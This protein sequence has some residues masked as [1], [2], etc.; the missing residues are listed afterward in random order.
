MGNLTQYRTTVGCSGAF[1]GTVSPNRTR[2]FSL[3]EILAV[4]T[5]L[6]VLSSIVVIKRGGG[7]RGNALRNAQAVT[8][9]LLEL[10]RTHATMQGVPVRLLIYDGS[11][12][13]ERWRRV[14]VVRR[15]GD[16]WE[17]F[18]PVTTLPEGVIWMPP[19]DMDG[20][21]IGSG[22]TGVKRSTFGHLPSSDQ[23]M[24]LTLP[25]TEDN[26]AWIFYE[27]GPEGRAVNSGQIV[28]QSVRS[29]GSGN[30]LVVDEHLAAGCRLRRSGVISY[31]NSPEEFL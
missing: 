3:I 18:Q 1:F 17:Q 27:F 7:G 26:A 23:R 10:A 8:G 21:V 11:N 19:A 13:E 28:L 20:P 5:I 4:V 16:S 2:G 31:I 12:A 15:V 24:N 30:F 22:V 25:G 29:N 14:A 6:M 9:S